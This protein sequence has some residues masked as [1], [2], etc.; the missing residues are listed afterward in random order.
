MI[1]D[2]ASR[3]CLALIVA[4]QLKHKDVLEAL[5]ELFIVRGSP[6]HI[7]SDNGA[8]FIATAV[9]QAWPG[10]GENALHCAG[11]ALG[12]RLQRQL[13]RLAARRASQ[14]EFFYSLLEA[15]VLVEG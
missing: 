10:R 8:E 15:K 6:A 13:Q 11:L 2:E 9:Q 4:R 5:A 14:C 12:E 7:T 3:E 1:I